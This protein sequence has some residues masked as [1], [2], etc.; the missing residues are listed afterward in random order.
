MA[1]TSLKSHFETVTETKPPISVER[2]IG[3]QGLR[4]QILRKGT[5]W[6]TPLLGDEVQGTTLF[7]C[8][9]GEVGKVILT[10]VIM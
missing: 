10:S 7:L 6:Q 4:K 1:T 2:E 3:K 8:F 9:S 5:S